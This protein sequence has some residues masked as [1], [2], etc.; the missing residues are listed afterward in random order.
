AL[1]LV[2]AGRPAFAAGRAG[3]ARAALRPAWRYRGSAVA[4]QDL[5]EGGA[6]GALL[7]ELLPRGW[8]ERARV[9]RPAAAIAG[10]RGH[11]LAVLLDRRRPGRGHA[12]G[13]RRR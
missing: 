2:L 1:D 11:G 10:R 8:G 5:G 6:V 9:A 7:R 12:V 3:R 13:L 4:G